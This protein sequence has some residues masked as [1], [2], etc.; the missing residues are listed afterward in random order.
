VV[1]Q[2]W[3]DTAS[4]VLRLQRGLFVQAR[5]E[6]GSTISKDRDTAEHITKSARSNVGENNVR[7]EPNGGATLVGEW[8][9]M[10]ATCNAILDHERVKLRAVGVNETGCL[11]EPQG[12]RWPTSMKPLII[13]A[14][15][16]GTGTRSIAAA[17]RQ[18]GF[19]TCHKLSG[20]TDAIKAGLA[21]RDLS[22]HFVRVGVV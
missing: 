10:T 8:P 19:S 5:H 21:D 13:G 6:F 12:R 9:P 7:R 15:V 17:V 16:G 4:S 1:G 18:L 3:A 11:I 22:M 14:G 2:T 20:T